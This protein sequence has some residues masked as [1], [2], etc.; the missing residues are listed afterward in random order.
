MIFGSRVTWVANGRTG[1]AYPGA[2]LILVMGL[3]LAAMPLF[4]YP[5]FRK[6][7]EPLAMGMVVFRG[8]LEGT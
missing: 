1:A 6:D 2:F 7:S 5:L 8:A 3:S 4:L